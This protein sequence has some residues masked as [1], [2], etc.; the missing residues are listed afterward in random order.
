VEPQAQFE[1]SWNVLLGLLPRQ[2]EQQAILQGA[3]ERTRGFE[4]ID[5]LLRTLLLHIGKGYSLRETTARAKAAGLANVSDV[6]LL[7]RLRKA[8]RWLQW[9]CAQLVEESGWEVPMQNAGLECARSGRN[10][11]TTM[12]WPVCLKGPGQVVEGRLCA[13]RKSETATR[14]EVRKIRRKAQQGGP[15]T[16]PETL[17]YAHYVMVFT[18]LPAEQFSSDEIL[19]WYRVRWQIELVFKRMKSL[20]Q[21]GHLPKHDEQSARAWLYG[22]LLVALLGQKLTRLGRDISP[23]GYRLAESWKWQ[24]VAGL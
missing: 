3:A 14:K 11:G 23:W 21:L 7:K 20:A 19:E 24:R 2:W 5:A 9:L 1:E 10:A 17:E 16:K 6:A 12:Q 8:E 13:V 4:S 18:T 15:Q 22:K